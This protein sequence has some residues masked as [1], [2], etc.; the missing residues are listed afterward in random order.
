VADEPTCDPYVVIEARGT[1]AAGTPWVR[2]RNSSG[3]RWEVFGACNH[4]GACWEG[5]V[6]PIPELDC[7]VTPAFFAPDNFPP[8]CS[9]TLGAS[10]GD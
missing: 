4:C 1:D 3:R 6:G 9:L 7:P 5:A 10:D 2:Y 8:T